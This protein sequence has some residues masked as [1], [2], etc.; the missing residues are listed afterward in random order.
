MMVGCS[1]EAAALAVVEVAAVAAAVAAPCS[2]GLE[3]RVALKEGAQ[4]SVA[5]TT[6]KM[7][8]KTAVTMAKTWW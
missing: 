2:K 5:A 4:A 8:E 7:E 3:R 6:T 1:Q